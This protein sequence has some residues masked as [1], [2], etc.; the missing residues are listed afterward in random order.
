[1]NNLSQSLRELCIT[2]ASNIYGLVLNAVNWVGVSAAKETQGGG[3]IGII[4]GYLTTGVR[5][6]MKSLQSFGYSICTMFFLIQL[7]ELAMSEQFTLEYFI[8]YFSKLVVG[9]IAV[10]FAPEIFE[11]L[12]NLGNALADA[13]GKINIL[14]NYGEDNVDIQAELYN[15][16][17]NVTRNSG[18]G[19][20]VILLM[21]SILMVFPL[22]I[23]A[24]CEYVVVY[25]ILA[26]RI[27]EMAIRGLFL[28]VALALLSDDG[29]K[30]SGGRYLKKFLAICVQGSVLVLIG[31]I[32]TAAQTYATIAQAEGIGTATESSTLGETFLIVLNSAKILCVAIAIAAAAISI[33]FKS[34]NVVNDVFGA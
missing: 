28:P 11:K 29:W 26:T 14:G 13:V 9:Y 2:G 31:K 30:G 24:L 5:D 15:T 4:Q 20:A 7:I 8:K 3:A 12:I 22:L 33:M 19:V 18:V 27:F 21:F 25:I 34:I 1:M 10:Y 23:A 32:S 17:D 16:F 6:G